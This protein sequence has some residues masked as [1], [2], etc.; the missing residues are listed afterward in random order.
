MKRRSTLSRLPAL[1]KLRP[2]LQDR[3]VPVRERLRKKESLLI[4]LVSSLVYLAAGIIFNRVLILGESDALSR[5]ANAYY[6]L[7]SRDPHLAAIGFI[8]PPLLSIL[9]I[10]LLPILRQFGLIQLAGV[11]ITSFFGGASLVMLNIVLAK[12]RISEKLRWVLV[13]LTFIHPN[14]AYLSAIGMTEP[15][16]IFFILMSVWGFLQMPYGTRSW[17][18]C[19]TGLA[20][21]F[22][23]RYESLGLMVGV[24]IAV[25]ILFWT[26]LGDGVAEVEGR[27]LAVLVPPAYGVAIW[28][29]LNW[30][31]LDNPLY[32]MI[33]EYSLSNAQDTAQVSGTAHALFLAWGNIFYTLSYT[34]ERIMQQN[35]AFLPGVIIV[36]IAVFVRKN[37]RMIGLLLILMVIPAFTALLLFMGSL[38]PWFRYW[39]YVAPFGAIIIGMAERLIKGVWQKI[40]IASLVVLYALSVPFSIYTMYTDTITEVDIQ[41][42]GAYILDPQKEPTLRSGDG[43]YIWRYDASIVAAKVDELSVD[44][45]V[46]I[47]AAKNQ[48]V[49]LAAEHP[50][51]LM[52]TNDSDFQEALK[53][54]RGKV[55]YILVQEADNIF[56]R[57]FPGIYNG[58]FDWAELIYEFPDTMNNYRIFEVVS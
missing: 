33:G 22:Y 20:L 11:L 42:L 18:I 24:A 56:S 7:Y 4:F 46:M 5:I 36:S 30:I 48:F 49:I 8:W 29:F 41:R 57:K 23:V 1:S 9:E 26:N 2:R 34:I 31:V 19:G 53:D 13:F 14:S 27:L 55:K 35:P 3:S 16:L 21:A 58:A 47:D 10:P 32:F 39:V 25:I 54:P 50:E 12:L 44:G 52:I 28:M 38:P 6:V 43:Y 37:R 40:S 45:L 15:L 51:R 17:V